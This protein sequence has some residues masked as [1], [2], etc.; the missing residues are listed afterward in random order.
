[1]SYKDYY[2]ILGV[3]PNA[4]NVVIRAAY[5]S[6]IQRYHPDKNNNSEE[7]RQRTL[8]INEAY[9]VLSNPAK[10]AAFDRERAQHSERTSF[11]SDSSATEDEDFY[12]S[13]DAADIDKEVEEKWK[14]ATE[15]HP[16]L[17]KLEARLRKISYRLS[18]GFKALIIE[19]KQFKQRAELAK[20]LEQQFLESYFGTN[21]RIIRFA[22]KL[23]LD[24]KRDAAIVNNK[25][26]AHI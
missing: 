15:F 5:R 25:Q 1:M 26:N 18:V 17:I 6:L 10:R 7:S 13:D 23:I 16:D 21:P 22:K 12:A 20:S 4:E 8:E 11:Y 9:E 3:L 24:N 19:T 2:T 14:F